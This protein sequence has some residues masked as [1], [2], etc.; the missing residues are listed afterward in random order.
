MLASHLGV[1]YQLV[2]RTVRGEINNRRV[3][4]QLLYLGVD[5]VALDLPQDLRAGLNTKDVA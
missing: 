4:C 1:S 2:H 3:L 5:P